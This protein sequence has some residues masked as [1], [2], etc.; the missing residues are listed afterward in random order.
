MGKALMNK[1]LRKLGK[2]GGVH[3][4]EKEPFPQLKTHGAHSR[5]N[6]NVSEKK[7]RFQQEKQ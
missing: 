7:R 6:R 2:D 1:E 3:S 4:A 5:M